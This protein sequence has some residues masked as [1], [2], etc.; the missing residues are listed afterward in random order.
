MTECTYLGHIVGNGVVNPEEGKLRQQR[1][2]TLK[3]NYG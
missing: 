2:Y 1:N 3:N